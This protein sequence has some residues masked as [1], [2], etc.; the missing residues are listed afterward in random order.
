MWGKGEKTEFMVS[1]RL[2]SI[3]R[4]FNV[5]DQF[6]E[7]KKLTKR[8]LFL[9]VLLCLNNHVELD[10]V[11]VNNFMPLRKE[12][13]SIYGLLN[14]EDVKD[15]DLKALVKEIGDT[16]LNVSEVLVDGNNEELPRVYTKVEVRDIK[17]TLINK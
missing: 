4:N 13:L 16:Y 14:D 7:I 1:D 2:V 9:L 8:E 3:Y 17:I 15:E 5:T 12:A 10:P 6:N 11:V